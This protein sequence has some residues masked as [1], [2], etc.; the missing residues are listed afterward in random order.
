MTTPST[1]AEAPWQIEIDRGDGTP[2]EYHSIKALKLAGSNM[3]L[4][5]PDGE[6][7]TLKN[8]KIRKLL[9]M[10]TKKLEETSA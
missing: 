1:A 10:K 5:L 9:V 3:V 8:R 7:V 6:Q 2:A 4:V